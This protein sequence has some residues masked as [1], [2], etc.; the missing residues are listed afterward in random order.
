MPVYLTAIIKSR[1]EYLGEVRE[2]L[3]G[4]V[5]ASRKEEACMQYDLY[6]GDLDPHVFVFQEIWASREGLDQ[7][8]ERPYIRAFAGSLHK[9]QHDP[10]IFLTQPISNR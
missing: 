3:L 4:M 5:T 2:T 7:H 10:E 6:Q 1:P 8:N 9:L